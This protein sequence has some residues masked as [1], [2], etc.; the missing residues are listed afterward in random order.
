MKDHIC[1]VIAE[2]KGVTELVPKLFVELAPVA[3]KNDPT[4]STQQEVYAK[5]PRKS[6]DLNLG[7]KHQ[8][9]AQILLCM[10]GEDLLKRR[11]E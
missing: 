2:H 4:I 9:I 10:V 3:L 11:L 6:F 7:V 5:Q 1:L 8:V